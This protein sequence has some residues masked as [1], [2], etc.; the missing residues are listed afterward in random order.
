M[1]KILQYPISALTFKKLT[2]SFVFLSIGLALYSLLTYLSYYLSSLDIHRVWE[3][4]GLFPIPVWAKT[5]PEYIAERGGKF[6]LHTDWSKFNLISKVIWF[7]AFYSLIY[8]YFSAG[9]GISRLVIE[10]ERGDPF[11]PLRDA[12]KE[13]FKKSGLVFT[14]L[15][16]LLLSFVIVAV[17]HGLISIIG[18]IP[19]A[20]YLDVVLIILTFPFLAVLS[21]LFLYMCI[22]FI[23]GILV[24]PIVA[25]SLEGDTFD[26]FYEGFSIFNERFFKFAFLEIVNF[27]IKLLSFSLFTYLV[28]QSLLLSAKLIIFFL[29]RFKFVFYP[30]LN[31]ISF[32]QLH[33]ILSKYFSLI[34]PAEF[35]VEHI[36]PVSSPTTY[37]FSVIFSVWFVV[38]L[39]VCLSFWLSLTWTGRTYVYAEIVKDK[40]GI[41]IFSSKP[42]ALP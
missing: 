16:T 18:R 10:S 4:H 34:I 21:L 38:F 19:N 6:V 26:I 12:L 39:I 32:P 1:K 17:I 15:L 5:F 20:F 13:S 37:I 31:L 23:I 8:S 3:I 25:T 29:P 24:G 2:L 33:P 30:N 40:D 41:D 42:K 9:I 7:L 11:Y 35:F 36:Q 28:F 22:G 27:I 14:T